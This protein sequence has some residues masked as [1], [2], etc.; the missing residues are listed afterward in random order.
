M[1]KG[2][3]TGA[4]GAPEEKRILFARH[5]ELLTIVQAARKGVKP[6]PKN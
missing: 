2:M 1:V 6:A 3:G 4:Y 5:P